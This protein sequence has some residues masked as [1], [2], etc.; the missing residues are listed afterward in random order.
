M[1]KTMKAVSALTI[2]ALLSSTI[3]QN[4][5]A[6]KGSE[7]PATQEVETDQVIVTFKEDVTVEETGLDIVGVDTVETEEIATLKVPEGETL[8]TYIE[9]LEAR[10]DIERVEPDHLVQLTYTP[11]DPYFHYYQYHHKN[12][13]VERAWDKTKGS[14]D[15][16]VAVLDQGFDVNHSDLVN[17]I[18]SPSFTSNTGLSIDNHGTH[19]AGI[20]G[21]SM[22]NGVFG[23]GVAP[24]TSIMPID[25]FEGEFAYTSDIVEGI[26]QAVSA[27]ADIINMSIGSYY[28]DYYFNN[29]VQYAY[30]SGV[31]IIAAAG[32]GST[33]SSHYP[34]SYENVI[35]VGSTDSYDQL[36]YFSNYGN[37]IDI[38]APGSSIYSTMPY[39]N[40]GIMS[41]TSMASPVVAGVA[42]LILANEPNLTNEEVANRLFSTAKDI[43]SYGKDY[44][45]GN[46]LVNAKQA[47]E[48]IDYAAPV[49]NPIQDYS[50]SVRGYLPYRIDYAT[51]LVRNQSGTVIGSSGYYHSYDWSYTNFD[52]D[53]PK[54]AAGTVLYVS[55]IDHL[56]NES[57]AVEMV[58]T[59]NTAPEKPIVYEVTDQ[60][61]SISGTGEPGALVSVYVND[62]IYYTYWIDKN[63]DFTIPI[64][65]L[66]AGVKLK[67]NV[68]DHAGNVGK[69]TDITVKDATAPAKP[70][71]NEVNENTIKVTGN[72]EAGSLV[73]VKAKD[74]VLGEA[75]ADGNRQYSISM[76]K[77]KAGTILFVYSTDEA[78]NVSEYTEL[79]VKDTEAPAMPTVE[80]VTDK[81]TSVKG[82]AEAKSFVSVKVGGT[83]VG[84]STAST[85]GSFDV[86]ITKQKAG[87]K[88]SVTATDNDGNVSAA[89][90]ITVLDVTPPATPTVNKVTD[91]STEVAG[92]SEINAT[93]VVKSNA[94]ELGTAK[95]SADGKY[96]VMID[97]QKAG[98]KIQVT[99]TDTAGNSSI[100]KEVIV[101]D[102]TAPMAPSVNDVTDKSTAITGTAEIASLVSVKA[103]ESELGIATADA[104]G[105]FSIAIAKQ[106][107][108]TKLEITATDAA[109]NS[110]VVKE[111]IV[112]DAT[113]PNAPTVNKIT[114]KTTIVTGTGEVN[115]VITIK[116]G[117]T[118]LR[119]AIVSASGEYQATIATQKAGTKIQVTAT[120]DAGNTSAIKE[121]TVLDATAPL[122]PMVDKVTDVS[123]AITGTAEAESLVTVKVGEAELGK[124]T[125]DPNGKFS[126]AI[127]KQ[128]ADTKLTITAKDATGNSSE[129]KEIIVLDVTPPATPTTDKVSDRDTS[130][131]GIGE[132]GSRISIIVG[133]N[134]IGTAIVDKAGNYEVSIPK[135]KANTKLKVMATDKA[136]NISGIEEI[137]VIDE[138]APLLLNVREVT[139]QSITVSGVTEA[140]SLI[141][142]KVSDKEI[143]KIIANS[144]GEFSVTIPKQK[145]GTKLSLT[146]TDEVGNVSEVKVLTV[147]DG[148]APS[149]PVVNE[150]TDKTAVITGTA[151]AESTVTVTANKV[152]LGKATAA[153]NGSYSVKIVM[154]KAG[155]SLS[156]IAT[157]T[158]GNKSGIK[159]VKVIDKTPPATPS[160]NAVGDNAT[161]VSGK[162]ETGAK[163]YAYVGSKKLGEA[164]SK[165]GAYSIKIAKQ[166][167]G[168]VITVYAIDLAK[169]KSAIRTTKVV[170][171]T[172]PS[173]PTVNNVT[174][175]STT[176]SGKGEK[177][178]T[179]LIYNGK[180]KVG[181]GTVDSKG[182]F[183]VKISAQK[184]GSSLNIQ[185]QDKAGNKSGSKIVKVG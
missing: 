107:A 50:T 36:S 133:T 112:L 23:T 119:S 65:L 7:P 149:S 117:S 37:D 90:D 141:S 69:F 25:V 48:I 88:L 96:K 153:L 172:A 29:A 163:V 64:N 3:G 160:V 51:I 17:Q 68:T 77:Q 70:L 156:V 101:I 139:D 100:T 56:N 93:I 102:A 79:K 123:T 9:E 170:D 177:A 74:V 158:A 99:A 52:V 89:K 104:D 115:S 154:Q 118:K 142:V 103:G 185:L 44:Y 81:S 165:N 26:Y 85:T 31:V 143:G 150:V 162:V 171:K 57:Q 175:K 45:F 71:V 184:K 179:V 161:I 105:K 94:E 66:T 155:T 20:I 168:T 73:T 159:T 1:K 91:K 137:I 10:P 75:I 16:V 86:A 113:A 121:V 47:L 33:T 83:E 19:V 49:V 35:S 30:Q 84:K 176:V 76:A 157:D 15:V 106:K 169:N 60:S 151:E 182:N 128:K 72:A 8:D 6:E 108:D 27:G 130:V 178:A 67:L 46:G 61:T 131:H 148:T 24:R 132:V 5:Y 134:E 166:K 82:T 63:G 55:V 80:K 97:T 140:G 78:G 58:V 21:S 2:A 110:S 28:Y 4:V 124:T 98:A 42:A 125:A 135:Q 127:A 14:S 147:L 109:G 18:V 40:I 32:N 62:T 167:A 34:S 138:T 144:N 174:S 126:I 181:Q 146:A 12:I 136:G 92:T 173:V 122:V 95:V 41:G 116:S 39:N 120:D 164:T 87:T 38:V 13:E 11:N 111:I 53:I 59:D 152:L 183:K 145:V 43:G 54:Q 22:D 114:D 180:K 129:V